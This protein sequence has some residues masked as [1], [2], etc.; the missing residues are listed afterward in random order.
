M[1]GRR[2]VWR[3][4]TPF[5][6]S[7]YRRTNR[8]FRALGPNSV[9]TLSL[10]GLALFLFCLFLPDA[11]TDPSILA[12]RGRYNATYPLTQPVY[13]GHEVLFK[14]GIISDPDKAS[15]SDDSY[16]SYMK[17]GYLTINQKENT[18][19]VSW[20]K[21]E[22]VKSGYS[23]SGRGMELSDLIV[24]NGDIL[25]VDDR[26]G[27]VFKII[28]SAKG[29]KLVPWQILS[30]GDGL[31]EKGFKA[32]WMTIKD[33]YLYVGGLGKE[34]ADSNGKIYHR[35]PEWVKKISP[36]G[37][38]QHLNWGA[39]FES[40]RGALGY[41]YPAYLLHE[42]GNWSPVHK[43]WFFLP[44]RT[45]MEPYDE[46]LDEQRGGNILIKANE[47]FTGVQSISIGESRPSRG[48]SAFRFI[49]GTDDRLIIALKTAE[50]PET[51]K[52]K[53]Y[54]TVFSVDGEVYLDDQHVE[55]DKY[56]GIDFL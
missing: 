28:E 15:R 5:I 31:Q 20:T 36:A 35:N 9:G 26:S 45:S 47:D 18:A 44:R 54:V 22:M 29:H 1:A 8:Q 17:Y 6:T 13:T 2:D 4:D 48:F 33:N 24:F 34:W 53:T 42:A 16:K 25:T 23:L 19:K 27:I 50:N 56:E 30:D 14:I 32:E 21:P 46:V 37:E 52:M 12:V 10:A 38:V 49:P 51:K 43:K 11:S 3:F 41:T 55:E 7:D 40:L 39:N